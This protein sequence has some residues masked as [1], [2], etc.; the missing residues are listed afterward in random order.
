[1]TGAYTNVR[2]ELSSPDVAINVP[3]SALIFNQSGLLVATVGDDERIALKR[4]VISR[5]L[6]RVVEIGSGLTP[7]DRVVES[8]PDGIA[9]GDRVRIVGRGHRRGVRRDSRRSCRARARRWRG[10]VRHARRAEGMASNAY[11][12]PGRHQRPGINLQAVRTGPLGLGGFCSVATHA[13]FALYLENGFHRKPFVSG[14]RGAFRES[15]ANDAS[16][17]NSLRVTW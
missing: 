2:L 8:P 4:V 1:M 3:A 7:D 16:D 13:R 12:R 17:E 15:V 14:P 10:G 6:G 9:D 5:D 11:P